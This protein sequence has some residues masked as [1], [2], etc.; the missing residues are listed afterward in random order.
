[1]GV[2]VDPVGSAIEARL[3]VVSGEIT[4][5]GAVSAGSAG[6]VID[7]QLNDA[8]KA[9]N[10]LF[11]AGASVRRA[12]ED[13]NGVKA[14]DFIVGPGTS[15]ATA[16]AIANETGVDFMALN[17]DASAVSHVVQEQRVGMYQRFYGGN[18]DEGWTRLMLENF[19][20]D[21]TSMFDDDILE[22]DLHEKYD[23]IILPADSKTMMMGPTAGGGGRG[24]NPAATPPEYRSG[25]GQEGVDALEAFVQNG[26]Q[27]V[28]FAQA[29]D[30]VLDEFEDVPVTN[31]VRGMSGNEFW[32]PGSTL[33]VKVDNTDAYG[34]GMHSRP[35]SPEV[36]CM[37]R[38]V[39]LA[40]PT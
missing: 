38:V 17:S 11:E 1:M 35:S 3:S 29:G 28:T 9:V 33:K 19:G 14:G 10:M 34:F 37:R 32:S 24:A 26:G 15:E 12:S 18:M 31:A 25:F 22:G 7:G 27:L 5:Q 6:Y 40:A 21:Y 2:R 16:R 23:V 36:R 4:P 39:A 30:L 8:F 13:G 20:F